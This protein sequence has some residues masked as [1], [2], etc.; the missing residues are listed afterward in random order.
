VRLNIVLDEFCNIPAIPDMASMIS[1]ARSRNMRFFLMAQGMH[2]LQFKYREDAETIKG[3]CDNWVFLTSREHELLREISNLCGE[4]LFTD[5]DGNLKSRPLISI[6]ELQRLK[7][8][9]GEAL[10]LHGRHYPFVTELP[11]IDEYEFN[12][13]PPLENDA[14]PLPQIVPYDADNVISDIKN[15]K[16]PLP[17]SIEVFGQVAYFNKADVRKADIFDW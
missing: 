4:T 14:Q 2:Q 13:Y 12:V 11:D 15:R 1:A 10:I 6:S 7:K 16:N 9:K 17:F 5:L 8:E 3:N